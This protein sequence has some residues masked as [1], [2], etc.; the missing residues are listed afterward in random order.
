MTMIYTHVT[1]VGLFAGHQI[2]RFVFLISP[3]S[4]SLCITQIRGLT[5]SGCSFSSK[6]SNSILPSTSL[7]EKQDD[8][9][10]TDWNTLMAAQE[11]AW[12]L[13]LKEGFFFLKRENENIPVLYVIVYCQGN[14]VRTDNNMENI[15]KHHKAARKTSVS[16]TSFNLAKNSPV[17]T[18]WWCIWGWVDWL[19]CRLE[20]W[21]NTSCISVSLG[22]DG[23]VAQAH[24][25]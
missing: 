18:I 9:T 16:K 20:I 2:A 17:V 1:P 13:T 6:M 14:T 5:E 4:C 10:I 23:A 25:R 15:S 22:P 11:N 24:M 12:I 3:N 8:L 19:C 7:K 21:W